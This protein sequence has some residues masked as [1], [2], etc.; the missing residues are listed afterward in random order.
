MTGQTIDVFWHPD[1][2]KHN[3]GS[4]VFGGQPSALMAVDEPHVEGA[5]RIRNMH[6]ILERGPISAY[7]RWQIGRAHV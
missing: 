4:G 2:L 3:P 6:S 5:D 1:A 7:L